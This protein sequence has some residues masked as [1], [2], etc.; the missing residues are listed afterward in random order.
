M[1][2]PGRQPPL[3]IAMSVTLY[4]PHAAGDTNLRRTPQQVKQFEVL[5]T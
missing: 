1:K 3:K 5:P 4:V 2:I